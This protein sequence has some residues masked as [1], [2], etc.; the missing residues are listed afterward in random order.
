MGETLLSEGF[1]LGPAPLKHPLN[2]RSSPEPAW[3]V[4]G[5]SGGSGGIGDS[6]VGVA[7]TTGTPG[8]ACASTEDVPREW[9]NT[10]VLRE[11]RDTEVPRV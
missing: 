10:A 8:W 3:W 9:G 6:R 2:P 7:G 4:G 5:A 11:G 1:A